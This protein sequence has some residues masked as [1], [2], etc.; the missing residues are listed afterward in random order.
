MKDQRR[1]AF[2]LRRSLIVPM[3]MGIAVSM[4][5][6][7][8]EVSEP[9][10]PATAEA[11]AA[12]E[13]GAAVAGASARVVEEVVVTARRRE[14]SLQEVPISITVVNQA[15]LDDRNVVSGADL[16]TYTP[17]LQ[18]KSQFGAEQS[19]FSIRG[20]SQELRTTASVG[21]YFADVVAP[22]GGGSVTS[23]D[24]AGPG[25]FFDLQNVQV[26]KGPQGTLFGRNT[27]G[28]AIMLVP[29]KPTDQLEGY[30]EASGG[31]F[32][33][34]RAQGVLNVPLTD[35]ARAR[36]GA[37]YHTRD[38]HLKNISGVGPSDLSNIDYIAGRASLVLDLSDALENYT[39]LSY[40]NS[41]NNGQVSALFAC[42]PNIV[43]GR[44]VGLA[45]FCDAQLAEQIA[46][47]GDFYT[48]QSPLRNPYSKLEQIQLINTT[49]WTVSD[50]LT[51]KNIFSFSDMEQTTATAVFGTNFQIPTQIPGI[52]G[53]RFPFTQSGQVP[54]VPTNSQQGFVEE[55]QF[56]GL[57]LEGRLTWQAGLYYETSRPD[58]LSGSQ[59]PNLLFCDE[60]LGNDPADFRCQDVIRQV[61]IIASGGAVDP[62]PS[63]AV[64][65]QIGEI[66]YENKA[67]YAQATYDLT[68]TLKLTGGLRYTWDETTGDATSIT[69]T[70]FPTGAPGSPGVT[71]C[72]ISFATLP[73]CAYSLQQKS[74]A[75]TWTVGL[76]Y[77]PVDGVMVYAKYSRG[78]RQ[79]S[80]SLFGGEGLQTF[81]PEEV[82][83][84]EIGTKTRFG[85]PV[86][87]TFNIAAFH[88]ELRDQ[89]LQL[90]LQSSSG[91]A[92]PT[93]G[94]LNAG[95]STI[96]GIEV[97]SSLVLHRDVTLD[98]S[99]AWLDTELK[100]L[101]V[102]PAPPG[103]VFDIR[104][105]SA[106][107]GG[108][109]PYAP[110]HSYTATLTYRLPVPEK[111]GDMA[112]G[113]TW[114][115]TDEQVSTSTPPFGTM[116]AYELLNLNLNW[117]S[118]AQ[119]PF[120]A[121]LFMTNALDEEYTAYVPGV[122]NSLGSEFRVVGLPRMWGAR[123][124]Y[125]F[126][127]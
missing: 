28:G 101:D 46:A 68:S 109:L 17:S 110:E 19:S 125:N 34:M 3:S 96:S 16:A 75:P 73:D 124:R 66:E 57:A 82:D 29:R 40:A 115:Y 122:Y 104:F 80:I 114:V 70:A 71:A 56:Q 117:K 87:G 31:D 15:T 39:I 118:I 21:F 38:G 11:V 84:Y 90:G 108:S 126:G 60:A 27:T 12:P 112:L 9:A 127:T 1:S 72:V 54:G 58:G 69:Y 103:A 106:I 33:L 86:P 35:W 93:T 22:R 113:V 13:T 123:L 83:S 111:L 10:A 65:R 99:Y 77:Q 44:R 91:A 48:V 67:V 102:P 100:S 81:E 74:D 116:P 94:I 42:N 88:N 25:A 30:L 119:S 55:L 89:Q 52:G 85:G 53:T 97:E 64:Q 120:D 7:A 105:P 50:T 47:G 49:T 92:Q 78:Y 51:I 14:E 121:A 4:P 36:F 8:Q 6:T 76:D 24:G 26:L 63:G 45:T 32:D 79:G 62:G 23:G 95:E 41:D 61:G 98:L 2:G 43:N 20:F 107:I 59:S 5:V 18:A 37:D